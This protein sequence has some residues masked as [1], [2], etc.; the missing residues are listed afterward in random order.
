MWGQFH[1]LS[2]NGILGYDTYYGFKHH[3]KDIRKGYGGFDEDWGNRNLTELKQRAAKCSFVV[4]KQD[5]LDLPPKTYTTRYVAMGEKQRELYDSMLLTFVAS[6]DDSFTP[7][8]TAR[9]TII[10]T[11]FLRL[12]QICS[13]FL[14]PEEGP[15]QS[16]DG[17]CPKL[18]A[19]EEI[20]DSF[21]PHSRF[22]IWARFRYDI[23]QI[24]RL[25]ARKQIAYRTITGADSES[26]RDATVKMFADDK[27]QVQAIVGN[28]QAGG[29]GLT[30][31]GSPERPVLNAIYYNNGF[32]LLQR[33]QSEDRCH[34]IGTKH[35]VTYHDIVC[36]DSID[37]SIAESLQ[38]K[39]EISEMMK[40][41]SGLRELLLGRNA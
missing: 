31:I 27:A 29:M 23:V 38:D 15:A 9:A 7:A 17:P 5:C 6:L 25:L 1:F 35:P 12:A 11:K 3:Y 30:L 22:I 10:L 20:V 8:G 34:R 41:M 37:E 28:T 33:V 16:I 26:A 36:E 4:R 32:S 21:E 39:R 19:L 18:E 40:D 24:T 13:G 2:Q 14:Q